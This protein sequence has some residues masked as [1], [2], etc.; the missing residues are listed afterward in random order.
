[1][2]QGTV[3]RHNTCRRFQRVQSLLINS[4]QSEEHPTQPVN[5]PY[6]TPVTREV[7]ST[8]GLSPPETILASPLRPYSS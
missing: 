1:M 2:D 4:S 6:P 3:M 8:L 7:K 5:S